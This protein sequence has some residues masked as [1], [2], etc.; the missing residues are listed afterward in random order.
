MTNA[1]QTQKMHVSAKNDFEIMKVIFLDTIVALL[2]SSLRSSLLLL[3][4]PRPGLGGVRRGKALTSTSR[5]PP[6]LWASI[7]PEKVS[8]IWIRTTLQGKVPCVSRMQSI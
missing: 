1:S 7:E 8:L 6:P 5:A 4:L 3:V 2:R